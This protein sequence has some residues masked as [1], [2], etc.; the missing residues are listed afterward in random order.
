MCSDERP[1]E[2]TSMIEKRKLGQMGYKA[3][4]ITLGGC[5]VGR[6][7]QA[8]A[9]RYIE[10]ALEYGVNMIDVAPTYGD[11]ELRLAPWAQK[12]RGSFFIAEKTR[13]RSR[14]GAEKALNESLAKLGVDKFDLYQMHGI[15]NMEELETALGEGGAIE[16]FKEAQETG[17]TDYIGI[18][19]HEDMRVLK[20][21][22]TRQV[23]DSVLLPVSLCSMAKPHPQ[24]DFRPVLEEARD[25]GVSVTAIKAVARGRWPGERSHGTWYEPSATLGDIE[26]GIRYTLSQEN[27]ATYSLPC[28]A[29]LWGM[30]LDAAERFEPMTDVE[31]REAVNYAKEQG[32]S[33]LFPM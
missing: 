11:A 32:F 24:N 33:P 15:G 16:A 22:L 14:E 10:L 29:G 2:K 26:L 28:D 25:Q 21:A 18:T 4:I 1:I 5:G 13:E 23:F 31:Q 27:V 17:L 8:V 12:M 19:G 20:E 3:S 30:V 9:D 6:V 7:D